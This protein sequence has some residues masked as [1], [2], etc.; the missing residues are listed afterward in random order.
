MK[1]TMMAVIAL[2]ACSS[3]ITSCKKDETPQITIITKTD[4]LSVN[5]SSSKPFVFFNF[6][7][8][9]VVAN[10]DSAST[11]WDFGLR[12][13]TFILNSNAYGPGNAGAILQNTLYSAVTEAPTTGYAYDT[14][15]AQKAIKDG[16]WYNYNPTT[17]SFSPKAGQTFFFRTADNFY[18]KMELLAVDYAAFV[19]MQPDKLMYRFRY[20]YQANGSTK[21]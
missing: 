6:K 17:R 8:G 15:S 2:V 18:V 20:T 5:F 3:L 19:G 9:V 4:S 10:A 12:F 1:Q 13:T 14:S 16:S 11:K 7:N 21:F